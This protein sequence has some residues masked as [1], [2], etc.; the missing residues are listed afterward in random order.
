MPFLVFWSHNRRPPGYRTPGTDTI[1]TLEMKSIKSS[2]TSF[3]R[4]F[5]LPPLGLKF[6]PGSAE[7]T[8]SPTK[9]VLQ[10]KNGSRC[11]SSSEGYVF[12]GN[13]TIGIQTGH[14]PLPISHW[15]SLHCN[16]EHIFAT[17]VLFLMNAIYR[18][19]FR[20]GC[21]SLWKGWLAKF[22]LASNWIRSNIFP[23][24]FSLANL[25]NVE[26]VQFAE[27]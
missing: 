19:T 13:W 15:C 20:V 9:V 3:L 22:W 25:L 24:G 1:W 2:I 7:Q 5:N 14:F 16:G 8:F 6:Y 4:S 21:C 11:N 23:T 27:H 18:E 10:G 12:T 26:N 17:F